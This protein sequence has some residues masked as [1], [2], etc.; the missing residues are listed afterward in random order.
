MRTIGG[1]HARSLSSES[2]ERTSFSIVFAAGM[3]HLV[4]RDHVGYLHDPCFQRLDRVPRPGHQHEHHGVGDPD[5]LDLALA[6]ADRL[7]ED[8]LLAG[9]IEKEQRLQRGLGQ[10]AQVAAGSHRADEDLGVEEVVGEPDAVAEEGPLRERARG[11]DRDHADR[12]FLFAHMPD[13]GAD[14]ARLADSRRARDPDRV[15]AA[16]RRIE[17]A[18]DLVGERIGILDQR[19]RPRERPPVA[20]ANAVGQ[21]LAGE[22]TPCRHG[23]DAKAAS[24]QTARC[25]GSAAVAWIGCGSG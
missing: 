25:V 16:R 15:G 21:R 22:V 10:P 19:D 20:G 12:A 5:H 14:Q 23:R 4:D 11:I 7:Q 3:V 17:V 24:A 8:E 18:D 13:E 6:G 1:L 9:R 2:T